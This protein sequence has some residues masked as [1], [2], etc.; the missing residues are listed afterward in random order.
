MAVE[1]FGPPVPAPAEP[2]LDAV[3]VGGVLD[4]VAV[5][6][7]ADFVDEELELPHAAMTSVKASTVGSEITL[8]NQAFP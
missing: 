4:V 5:A 6:A 3:E 7:G 1:I 8:V 2:V